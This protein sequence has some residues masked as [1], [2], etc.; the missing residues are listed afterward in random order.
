LTRFEKDCC[1]QMADHPGLKRMSIHYEETF[2][3]KIPEYQEQLSYNLSVLGEKKE[4]SLA[5]IIGKPDFDFEK[6]LQ[7]AKN[8]NLALSWIFATPTAGNTPYIGLERMCELGPILQEFLLTCLDSN[9]ETTPALPVPL[10]MFDKNFFESYQNDLHLIRK[11]RPFVYFKADL[12]TQ[13]CSS[14]P[15]FSTP[16]LNNADD[17]RETILKYREFDLKLKEQE[18]FSECEECLPNL[19]DLCQGGCMMYKLYSDPKNMI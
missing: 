10:C 9:I 18:T 11:C 15:Y 7:L 2:F 4:C 17:L 12:S 13:Y 19:K 5:L 16:C 14:M 8:H 1:H 3:E 6:P